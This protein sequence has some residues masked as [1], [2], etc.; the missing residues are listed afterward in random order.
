MAV[1]IR[2][3]AVTTSGGWLCGPQMEFWQELTQDSPSLSFLDSVGM[4]YEHCVKG[5]ERGFQTML[6]LNSKSVP[7]LRSYAAFLIEVG[8]HV[9]WGRRGYFGAHPR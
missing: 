3:L 5:A 7:T 9:G 2:G 6:Q 4:E 8:A 1:A